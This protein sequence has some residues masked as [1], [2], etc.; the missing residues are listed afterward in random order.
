M[1]DLSPKVPAS[2]RRSVEGTAQMAN[3]LFSSFQKPP[4]ATP[5]PAPVGLPDAGGTVEPASAMSAAPA[6][7][8]GSVE[9]SS[10]RPRRPAVQRRRRIEA[11]P[12]SADIASR[13]GL[14]RPDSPRLVEPSAYS[15]KH[16]AVKIARVQA[17]LRAGDLELLD[18]IARR[19]VELTGEETNRSELLRALVEAIDRPAVIEGLASCGTH[20][21]RVAFLRARVD[22]TT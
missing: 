5:E 20:R 12:S 22:Q 13:A 4:V 19:S 17:L 10:P 6:T 11:D 1:S 14:P 9:P 8:Q 16:R 3:A 15:T 2:A 21:A 7:E 18:E